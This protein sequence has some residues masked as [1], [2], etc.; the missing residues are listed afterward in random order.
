MDVVEG[1]EVDKNPVKRPDK[2][3]EMICM[4]EKL[5]EGIPFVR[6]DL[7]L[8]DR[9]IYFGEMTFTPAAG[10]LSHFKDAFLEEEGKY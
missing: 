8:A 9:K 2:L 6:V 5:G 3:E 4:A 1:T 10:V 7:Y